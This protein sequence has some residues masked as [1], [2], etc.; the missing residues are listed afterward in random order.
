VPHVDNNGVRLHWDEAGSGSPLLLVMGASYSSALWYPAIPD[1][2]AHHRVIWFDNRGTGDSQA[3]EVASISDMVSDAI[4]VLDAAGV[5]QAHV[6]G[7]SLGGVIVQ[8]LALE[9]PDRV[10]SLV[11]GCTG[12]LSKAKPRAPK[13]LD[14]RFRLP[15]WAARALA[16]LVG[17]N[18]GYGPA[19]PEDRI[20][21]D[22]AVL[23]RETPD[24]VALVAQSDALRA[25]SVE[26]EQVATIDVPVLVLHGTADGIVKHAWGVELAETLPHARLVS[27]DG[28]GH[29]YL[30]GKGPEANAEVLAHLAEVDALVTP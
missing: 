27:Y 23:A 25:Y 16:R 20:A 18:G 12:I 4:A 10:L 17:R 1:L 9:H 24:V 22:K 3:T 30:V 5:E 15:G 7:V 13:W 28:I 26:P 21:V 8:Q 11:L 14:V 19:C 29:N 6:Y 2:S